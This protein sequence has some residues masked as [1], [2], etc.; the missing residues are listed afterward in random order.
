MMMNAEIES[1]FD[2]FKVD[3]TSIPLAYMFYEGKASSYL[4]YSCVD[5]DNSYSGDDALLGY[6]T[7]YDIEINCKGNYFKI[8]RAVVDKMTNAGWEFE[9]SL[10]SSDQ[11]DRDTKTYSKTLCFAKH[12]QTT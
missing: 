6:V 1:I 9:P 7:Y 2:G 3:S 8:L 11:Y 12:I 10:S 5:M 4:V